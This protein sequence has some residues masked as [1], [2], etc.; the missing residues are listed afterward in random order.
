MATKP[1][2]LLVTGAFTTAACYDRLTP[3]LHKSGYPTVITALPSANPSDPE[4]CSA[5]KDGA[6]VM[7][8]HL[9]PLLHESRDVIIF[10]HSLGATTLG[11][12]S[13]PVGK[14]QREARGA[15]GGVLG[16]VYMSFAFVKE[17]QT[18]LEFLGGAWPA[19]C[20]VGSVR[21]YFSIA[22][23]EGADVMAFS[24]LKVS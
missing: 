19:F 14:P 15:K 22:V 9:L 16:L 6:H 11:G 21:I 13:E 7:N 23:D 1:T 17:G 4:S 10:A 5:T 12:A 2:I 8:N 20:K 24:R 18:Q 3:Y